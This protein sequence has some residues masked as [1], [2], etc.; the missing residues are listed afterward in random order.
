MCIVEKYMTFRIYL[1]TLSLRQRDSFYIHIA[2]NAGFNYSI[3]QRTLLYCCPCAWYRESSGLKC[4]TLTIIIDRLCNVRRHAQRKHKWRRHCGTWC[5]LVVII[6][7]VVNVVV[8]NVAVVVSAALQCTTCRGPR[9]YGAIEFSSP[10]RWTLNIHT[11]GR[12][13]GT[14]HISLFPFPSFPP[15][16]AQSGSAMRYSVGYMTAG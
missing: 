6:V 7:V 9:S 3:H 4:L 12:I 11:V 10:Q 1:F 16:P 13:P 5:T 8:V 2:L 15:I 14:L